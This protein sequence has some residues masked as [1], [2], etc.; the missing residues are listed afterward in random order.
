MKTSE[1]INELATA[2]AKFQAKV[3]N[4]EKNRTAKI[5]S[6][7]GSFEYG[8]ADLPSVYDN[9]R[10]A[11]SEFGLSHVSTT[12]PL[13]DGKCVLCMRLLHTSGQWIESQLELI[14]QFKKQKGPDGNLIDVFDSKGLAADLTYFRRYLFMGLTGVAGDEDTD[15]QP[16]PGS[17]YEPKNAPAAQKQLA[18]PLKPDP[19]TEAL[20]ATT[21]RTKALLDALIGTKWD[22]ELHLKPYL[23]AQFGTA[24]P[25]ELTDEQ[26]VKAVETIKLMTFDQ[27][28]RGGVK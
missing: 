12:V 22:K 19:V 5:F 17:T 4:P 7:K 20:L 27:A 9:S 21:K 18:S 25:K 24:L 3:R 11:L 1:Q 10:A 26:V 14:L 23:E 8:Y 28:M 13:E 15:S 2:L 16:E 6:V